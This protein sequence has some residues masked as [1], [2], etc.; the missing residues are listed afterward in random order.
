MKFPFF[1]S[2]V[3]F[4]LVLHHNMNKGKKTSTQQEADFWKH[5]LDANHVRKQSLDDL[6]YI[7]FQAETFY[8]LTLLGSEACGDFF[9]DHPQAKEIV[10][11]FLYLENQKIVNL[12]YLT[13]TDLKYKYGVANLNLLIEYDTN[14]SELIT[15]LQ[16]Y[17]NMLLE[18]GFED[19]ALT[20]LE[21]SISIG[22][23]I[24]KT[25]TTC[26]AIYQTRDLQDKLT[27]LKKE[28]EK[29]PT[30]R[31][32]SIVRKLQEFDPCIG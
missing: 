14:Y 21:Y 4:I 7:D 1:A 8:P 26:A 3:I 10:S 5:E 2:F 20:V 24:S 11:R 27:W 9:A 30:S 19:A 23:D 22:S 12:S 29:I 16:N 15:L 17:G 25:Y 32:D 18:S 6:E 13:N 31:K 28:A